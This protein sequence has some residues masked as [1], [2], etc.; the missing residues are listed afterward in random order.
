MT[1]PLFPLAA[2]TFKGLSI[3]TVRAAVAALAV[4]AGAA[5]A[6]AQE[7]V[8]LK[9]VGGLAGINQFTEHEEPFWTREIA[10]ASGGR[11]AAT[12][13]PFDRSGLRG[14]DMLQLIR[15]GVVPFGTALLS[16]VSGDEPELSAMDLPALNP[17]IATLRRSL[18]V[19]RPYLTRILAE[20]YS[21]ELLGVYAYPAQVIYCAKPFAGL[22]DLRGRRVRTSSVAQSEFVGALGAT[23][24]ITP[25]SEIVS[26]VRNGVVDCAI[27]G[28]LSGHEIGLSAVTTHVHALSLSWGVSIF[29]ASRGAWESIDPALREVI[30]SRIGGLEARIWDAAERETARGLACNIGA[31]TCA[32]EKPGRMTLVPVSPADESRRRLLLVDTVLPTWIERC[33]PACAKA[34]NETLGPAMGLTVKAD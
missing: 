14:Q 11:I 15:L 9:I 28:T 6:G 24:V 25:F 5:G 26:A 4:L 16:V 18:S 3:R 1:T 33:G 27:T 7:P 13:H 21:I 32:A 12:I 2:R 23:P 30:R 20:R 19:Y 22:S 8:R 31:P 34:W 17:D 10:E 29:G